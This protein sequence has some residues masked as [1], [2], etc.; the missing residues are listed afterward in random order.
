VVAAS[1]AL[2]DI[3]SDIQCSVNQVQEI[4]RLTREQ[5]LSAAKL[6]VVIEQIAKIA[7]DN[8]SGTP[9]ATTATQHQTTA[10]QALAASAQ[11]LSK[12]SDRLKSCI[13]AFQ[14]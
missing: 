6:V 11:E 8:A 12:T 5:T 4:T 2:Q 3:V 14:Y 13:S 9:Q 7:E 10:M 1:S